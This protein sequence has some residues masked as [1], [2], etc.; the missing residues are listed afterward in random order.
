MRRPLIVLS[1]AAL[2]LSAPV[3][4]AAS[5]KAPPKAKKAPA[6]TKILR[7]NLDPA[8]ADAVYAK[9]DGKAQLVDGRKNDVLTVHVRRLPARVPFTVHVHQLASGE[10]C[11][12]GSNGTDTAFKVRK[13]VKSNAGGNLNATLRTRGF[14]AA[15]DKTYYVELHGGGDVVVVCGVLKARKPPKKKGSSKRGTTKRPAG[16][17]ISHPLAPKPKTKG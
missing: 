17:N 9:I 11:K 2:V 6:K 12:P 1:S 4:D 5:K 16:P 8:G 10:A 3:A 13:T 7:A 15:K 14:T